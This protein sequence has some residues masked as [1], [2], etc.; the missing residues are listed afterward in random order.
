[1]FPPSSHSHSLPFFV[2]FLVLLCQGPECSQSSSL[3]LFLA[4]L[5]VSTLELTLPLI[6]PLGTFPRFLCLNG[7]FF[8]SKLCSISLNDHTFQ[9]IVPSTTTSLLPSWCPV[10]TSTALVLDWM[11]LFSHS[12]K[13]LPYYD[14]SSP[15]SLTQQNY[16]LMHCKKL[17]IILLLLPPPLLHPGW[18]FY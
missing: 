11:V 12:I 16:Q 4:T 14:Y 5:S 3:P 10:F 18:S 9:H 6:S 15:K 7:I 2:N 1:M 8:L 17:D 13:V